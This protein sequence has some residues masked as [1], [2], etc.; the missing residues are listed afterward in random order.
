MPSPE[1]EPQL[2]GP[3][4]RG[5]VPHETKLRLSD[6]RAKNERLKREVDYQS[7]RMA[8]LLPL[9]RQEASLGVTLELETARLTSIRNRSELIRQMNELTGEPHDS[10]SAELAEAEA[11]HRAA[12][13]AL[14]KVRAELLRRDAELFARFD[15][16]AEERS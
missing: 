3:N 6:A 7:A 16:G 14:G 13:Q 10:T 8:E 12:T 4:A 2:S 5:E 1:R 11:R 15:L 9:L